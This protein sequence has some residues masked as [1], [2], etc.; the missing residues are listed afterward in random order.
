[1]G[2]I[3]PYNVQTN[4]NAGM[5]GRAASA[6]DFGADFSQVGK[7]INDVNNFLDEKAEKDA[8]YSVQTD[9]NKMRADWQTRFEEL[10]GTAQPGA[11]DFT[12][13]T[14][15]EFDKYAEK[16][17][18]DRASL[19]AS[20]RKQ[21]ELNIGEFRNNL[22]GQ[23]IGFASRAEAAKK[24][25]DAESVISNSSRLVFNAPGQ[26]DYEAGQFDKTIDALGMDATLAY[27]LKQKG[28]NEIAVAGVRGLI[29]KNQLSMARLMIKEGPMAEHIT[30]DQAAVL[31][32]GI[33][34][35][36]RL[37]E[38]QRRMDVSDAKEALRQASD[39][40]A[41]GYELP[42]EEQASLGALVKRAGDA[43]TSATYDRMKSLQQDQMNWRKLTPQQLQDTILTDLQPEAA[44][45]GTT[46]LEADRL[47]MAR[48]LLN[49]MQ[50]QIKTDPLGWA[51]DQKTV[52]LTPVD[53]TK[54]ETIKAR[55]VSAQSVSA[56][57][58]NTA[59]FTPAELQQEKQKFAGM[60]ADDKRV[61]VASLRENAGP[62]AM[63]ALSQLSEEGVTDAY[64][65]GLAVA[66]KDHE[67]VATNAWRGREIINKDPSR[68]PSD[69]ATSSQFRQYIGTANKYMPPAE[70]AAVKE[71]ADALY[72][73]AGGDPKLINP[74]QYQNAVRLAI[75]GTNSKD[76]TGVSKI[77]G[78]NVFLPPSTTGG[79]F[80]QFWENT[81][82]GDLDAISATGRGPVYRGGQAVD[83][84]DIAD[85][86]QFYLVAP[87]RYVVFM[88]SDGLP[89]LDQ[90]GGYWTAV[91]DANS[92]KQAPKSE[93]GVL[94]KGNIDLNTR[95]VVKNSD[96]SV[97]TVR[98]MSFEENGRE[99]LIPTV[100]HD[101][102]IMSEKEAVAYYRKTGEHLGKFSSVRAA[103]A[104]AEKLHN[105]QARL[106]GD[107]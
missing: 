95:P 4:A 102:K 9:S 21:M 97:S 85:Q 24:R 28:K 20:A 53:M 44:K 63:L 101:G 80:R 16:F 7:S 64:I 50:Q 22:L 87:N 39:R 26:F 23:S 82:K 54:P 40:M 68:K 1:M 99:V 73:Q 36:E 58:G 52:A 47:D 3:K 45:A 74:T 75:G 46:A 2:R 91:I 43:S 88:K 37:L 48:K 104:Y 69:D 51:S 14:L 103:D 25:T 59:F 8:I 57:Y 93:T 13:N 30:G 55:A 38:T 100:S 41:A 60:G 5:P 96:G 90:S 12:K 106:Y 11:P 76:D 98:S 86:G 49:G 94:E 81:T 29:E 32:N 56:A 19:P 79:Q 6:A 61:Y 66:S 62:A 15:A 42:A 70:M 72:V 35:Q 92:V 27:D 17:S 67:A 33:Q 31:F 71:T 34:A 77:N 83:P 107:K 84:A 65:G 18:E 10:Q 89:L 78:V 105:D